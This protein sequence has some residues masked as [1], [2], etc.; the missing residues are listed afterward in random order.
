MQL[1]DQTAA[2]ETNIGLPTAGPS[3]TTRTIFG[4]PLLSTDTSAFQPLR[5]GNH[6]NV[7]LLDPKTGSRLS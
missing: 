4:S 5:D 7:V 2:I 3:F 6:L 1:G